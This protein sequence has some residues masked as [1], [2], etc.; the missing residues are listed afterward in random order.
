MNCVCGTTEWDQITLICKHC[1]Q[2]SHGACYSI[3]SYIKG[4][5]HIC[6][7][8][9]VYYNVTCTNEDIKVLYSIGELTQA[10]ISRIQE[11]FL[12]KKCAV[13]YLKKEFQGFM[14]P[15][16]P[17][18]DFLQVKFRLSGGDA[19]KLLGKLCAK[20]FVSFAQNQVF[21]DRLKINHYFGLFQEE[22]RDRPDFL[23]SDIH[24]AVPPPGF[25]HTNG[26]PPAVSPQN[27]VPPFLHDSGYSFSDT[28]FDRPEDD[29]SKYVNARIDGTP[30]DVLIDNTLHDIP[31]GKAKKFLVF[32][33]KYST[34]KQTTGRVG[35]K[36]LPIYEIEEG[37]N[38]IPLYGEL[39][40]LLDVGQTK[41]SQLWNVQFLLGFE[42]QTVAGRLWGD[43]NK[44]ND[45]NRVLL[46]N[47]HRQ[48]VVGKYYLLES[49][50]VADKVYGRNL[51][52]TILDR[53]IGLNYYEK[54]I[55][56]QVE[57]RPFSPRDNK[58]SVTD[59]DKPYAPN[60]VHSTWELTSFHLSFQ[61]CSLGTP[62]A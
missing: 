23:S 57:L 52:N 62:K 54:F 38:F 60:Y 49:Y 36:P 41:Q 53:S 27:I 20:D 45:E 19:Y 2:G 61:S 26:P 30:A 24:T 34:L 9:A 39:R 18:E 32:P 50:S 46:G 5:Q 55:P 10:E 31:G 6:G 51:G 4:F 25:Q 29:N 17:K 15:G 28:S 42:D 40:E 43:R 13:A 56:L 1:G 47:I 59:D 35:R 48:L 21:V 33:L 12:F 16:L 44:T 37:S 58:V 22:V 7:Q 14:G 8:C 3:L 11:D